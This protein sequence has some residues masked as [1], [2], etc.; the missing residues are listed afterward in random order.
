MEA[1]DSDETKAWITAERAATAKAF[2]AMPE[3]AAIRTRL[4][5]LW[6]FPKFG[7]PLKRGGRLFFT[8][9]DGL[10]NQ[11]VL[12]VTDDAGKSP[13][14]VLIDPNGLSAEGTVAL[15]DIAASDDG[16]L[17][18]YG[19]ATAG[20]DWTE[21]RVRDVA[22]GA[23][24]PDVVRWVKFS[25][26]SWTKDGRG[27]FYTRFP[28][29]PA[30]SALFG[31]LLGQQL[32]YHALGTDQSADRLVFEMREH[33]QWLMEATVS[34]DGRYLEL[35]IHQDDRT[36]TGLYYADLVDPRAPRIGA[37]VVRLLD[38]F[39][40]KYAFVGNDGPVFFVYTT[41][42]APRGEVVAF[43]LAS[44]A[45]ASW[46][47]VVPQ[48][49]D[50]IEEVKYAG[51][52]LVVST[53]HDVQSR[54]KVYAPG[55][56]FLGDVPLPGI[57][58]VS[59][60]SARGDDP[61][62]FYRFS[63]FLIPPSIL[64]LNLDT[65][66]N[67]V[68]QKPSTPFN[69]S[70]FVTKEVF[71]KSR[72]GTQIPMFVTS[73]KNLRRDGS[74]AA[75]LYGYGGFDISV[76]PA[77]AVPPA[78]WLELGGI[79]VQANIRGGGEYGEKWHRA[80]MRENKQNVFDDYISAA[81]YLVANGYTKRDRLVAEG[82]SNGGLLIGAVLNQRPD[83]CAVALPAVGVMDML[84]YQR[85]TIG[86]AWASDYGTSADP[87][88][89]RYLRSY[90]PV[91]TVRFG[92]RYPPVLITTGD[93]DDRVFPAH[94]FKYAAE[95]QRAAA[96]VEGSGPVLIRIDTNTGHGGSTGTSPVSKTI[97]EWADR[98][99]FAAHFMPPGTLTLPG[100]P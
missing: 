52:R 67:A 17:L 6:N 53:L 54:L 72:D 27:F 90:S 44:P 49:A 46:R 95:M 7:L 39:D 55:G 58:A 60:V 26:L 73:R 59:G 70:R 94:S 61:E 78:V 48:T 23:D 85:F 68:F 71:F 32:Y 40:A 76:T 20:S 10:Q 28:E 96:A 31:K 11:A 13:P 12:Y 74:S 100:A 92:A 45:P 43:P 88:E 62:I 19:L 65:G 51:K 15:T 14:R 34:D 91:H 75:W 25:N 21:Y 98:M 16:R 36:E 81:D 79:Y 83:L 80:G 4:K 18:G 57:G 29:V 5:A 82:R 84:R 86:A 24:L 66:V 69:T 93:H 64:S 63:S 8:K 89:F 56:E 9:N 42:D 1:I 30:D 97:D 35:V 99:G 87:A 77:Y 50:S 47:A 3:R 38:R 2:E 37:P 33:P 41:L 22:T